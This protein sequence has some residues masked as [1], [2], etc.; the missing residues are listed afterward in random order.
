LFTVASGICWADGRVEGRVGLESDGRYLAGAIVSIPA[1]NLQTATDSDG[2]FV[3]NQV[4]AGSYQLKVSYLSFEPYFINIDVQD[5]EITRQVVRLDENWEE[6]H[7]YGRQT[8]SAASAINQQRAADNIK[9]VVSATEIGQFPDSNVSEALQRV[10]GVFLERDQGEGRFVGIR[11]IDPNLVVTT[12]NGVNVPAPENDKRSVALDVIPA[13]LLGSLEVSKSLTPDMDGDATGGAINVKSMSAFDQA[14]RAMSVTAEASRNELENETSPKL[15]GSYSDLFSLGSGTDNFGVALAVSWFD[16]DFGSENVES[17]GWPSDLETAGGAEFKGAEEI[18]QRD[19]VI[20]R[21]RLGAAANFDFRPGDYGEWYVRTLYSEFSDQEYRNRNT[22]VFD[23]GEAILGTE[24][25]AIWDDATLEKEL[26]DR[27]EEQTILSV[28]LGGTQWLGA[29]T[30][31]YVYGYSKSEEK[32]PD[33]EYATF[34]FEGVQ[35]GY[36][37]LGETPNL[38][39]DSAAQDP[40]RFDLDEIV[41]EDNMTED[42]EHSL[43]L[44]VRRDISSDYYNGE[45]K[46]GTK[47]R[48]REKTNDGEVAVYDG[49]PDDPTMAA[50][51]TKVN[52]TEGIFGPAISERA[53]RQFIRENRD[54][55]ELDEEGT[56]VESIVADYEINE[57]VDAFYLMSR[58]DLENLRIVYGIR[59][60]AT[61]YDAKGF[62]IIF[63]EITGE[64][65]PAPTSVVFEDDYDSWLPSINV[66][67]DLSDNLVV[68]AA[69][70]E[71]IARPSFG[72][73]APGGEIELEIDDG[74][75][76]L[77]AELGNPELE[78]LEASNYDVSVEYYSEGLG[79]LS[80]GVFYKD[81]QNFV[82]LA[83]TAAF[84]D[85]TELVGS[86]PIDDAEVIQ[87]INGDSADVLGV[88]LVWVQKFDMLPGILSN[89]LVSANA[90]FTDGE[91]KV[92]LR[93]E[94]ID[95]PQQS[96]QVLNLALGYETDWLSAR[97][98][99]TSKSDVLISLEEPDDPG[100]DVYQD[101]HVQWDFSLQLDVTEAIRINFDVINIT[102]EPYY[103]YFGSRRY[104]AQYE[105][106]GRTFGLGVRYQPR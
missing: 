67:Y 69:W 8:A 89:F 45:I 3:L 20:N 12:I 74:A 4:P 55:F 47:L 94:K 35:L 36:N 14:E 56:L 54:A 11:G 65:D 81:L 104:N 32:E 22:Y 16:R 92:P 2:S 30:F 77:K 62:R 61:D 27:Y 1:L 71:T 101:D 91:A 100:F 34:V 17:G 102:D 64:G 25:S 83:D 58:Y 78:P 43:K 42:E 38:F 82:V 5:D 85:L 21:E 40:D 18:E 96:D 26:K 28:A 73:L 33:A 98:A 48:R 97:L 13:E 44:D 24:D 46:F 50:F 60:E 7:V 51:A 95:L 106:Y 29:W 49:F 57:D 103:A 31:D 86:I 90:T 52:Y 75:N 68:R 79:L 87:P 19:Y 72:F 9:S 41:L 80:A 59:Y 6:V 84:I 23:D 15:S 53:T 88:E 93:D 99:Y 37:R 10:P 39:F 66:R 105:T 76:T 70:Y 63:D